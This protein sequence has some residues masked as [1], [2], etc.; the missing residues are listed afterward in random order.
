MLRLG[1]DR[2]SL[3]YDGVTLHPKHQQFQIYWKCIYLNSSKLRVTS[4]IYCFILL[5]PPHLVFFRFQQPA[6][7]QHFTTLSHP[8]D[9][10]KRPLRTAAAISLRSVLF[11][12]A[13]NVKTGHLMNCSYTGGSL[14]LLAS[15]ETPG[16]PQ[17]KQ[18]PI[19]YPHTPVLESAGTH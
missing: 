6:G 7:D 10:V 15:Y 8:C 13:Q 3:Q 16:P 12:W 11:I 17:T 9:E 4:F 2:C 19:H 5:V 1:G 14:L 18:V